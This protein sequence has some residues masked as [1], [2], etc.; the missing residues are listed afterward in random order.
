MGYLNLLIC[1]SQ[2]S[3]PPSWGNFFSFPK[4]TKMNLAFNTELGGVLPASWGGSAGGSLQLL[5]RHGTHFF[6]TSSFLATVKL[7]GVTQLCETTLH[8][9]K[10]QN[11]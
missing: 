1:C 7:P 8:T 4:L 6:C 10:L 2:G 5:S 9:V 3:L 11:A